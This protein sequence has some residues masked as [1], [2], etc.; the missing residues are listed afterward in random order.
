M[1]ESDWPQMIMW[2]TRIVRW[3]TKATDTHSAYVILIEFSQQQWLSQ[4]TS[5]RKHKG[6]NN[7]QSFNTIKIIQE[8]LKNEMGSFGR[9]S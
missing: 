8:L 9:Q 4:S 5:N 3:I 6:K 1:V 7:Q 2:R